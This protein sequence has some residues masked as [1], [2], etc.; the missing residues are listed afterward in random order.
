MNNLKI[1]L[2]LNIYVNS[3]LNV[4]L[5]LAISKVVSETSYTH[6][7]SRMR[8][9]ACTVSIIIFHTLKLKHN[10]IIFMDFICTDFIHAGNNL[11]T[12]LSP[13]LALSVMQLSMKTQM[14]IPF[15][16]NHHD[17]R[18]SK[19]LFVFTLWLITGI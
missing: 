18:Y 3:T 15:R 4:F 2:S 9:R 17:N 14:C 10:K 16:A 7:H 6:T 13:F 12:M 19:Q 11:F 1:N 5:S 8:E